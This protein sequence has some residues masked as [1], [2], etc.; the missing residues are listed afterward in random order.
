MNDHQQ[1]R[2]WRRKWRRA[3]P[4]DRRAAAAAL[5]RGLRPAPARWAAVLA[6]VVLSFAA[7]A[8]LLW[9]F[10]HHLRGG[11]SALVAKATDTYLQKVLQRERATRVA[12]ELVRK[13]TMPPPPVDPEAVVAGALTDSLVTDVKKIT[14]GLLDVKLQTAMSAHVAASLKDELAEASKQIAEGKLS[15][16]DIKA[17][18]EKF[19]EKAHAEALAWQKNYREEKQVEI[20]ALSTTEWYEERLSRML[21]RNIAFELF[22]PPNYHAWPP[23]KDMWKNIFCGGGRNLSWG[24][25]NSL[26][27]LAKR[28]ARIKDLEQGLQG[29]GKNRHP[30]WPGPNE[31]QAKLL[32]DEL[33]VLHQG[34]GGD[35]H[36]ERAAPSWRQIVYGGVDHFDTDWGRRDIYFT[37]GVIREYFPHVAGEIRPVAAQIDE[38]WKAAL[39]S[40]NE[41]LELATS[42]QSEPT[43]LKEP[44]QACFSAMKRVRE[45]SEKLIPPDWNRGWPGSPHRTINA[46]LRAQLLTGPNRDEMYQF[47]VERLVTGLSPVVQELV[48]SQ[49]EKGIIVHKEGIEQA[50]K[51]FPKQIVP[52][53]RR[54]VEKILGKPTFEKIVFQSR[55]PYRT[56]AGKIPGE[57]RSEPNDKALK[58]DAALLEKLLERQP[59]LKPYAEARR[60]RLE[61]LWKR[62]LVAVREH[63]LTQ[64]LSGKLLLRDLASYVEGVEYADKVQEKLDARKRAMDGRGQD[65]ARL[66]AEGVPDTSAPLVA[67]MFGASKGHGTSIEP[68]PTTMHPGVFAGVRPQ[69]ALRHTR[70]ALPPLSAKWDL[71]TQAEAKPPFKTSRCEAIPF[72]HRIPRLDGDLS[73]WGTLRPLV[74][75]GQGAE[76]MVYAAWNYQGFFFAYR[77]QQPAQNFYYP[78]ASQMKIEKLPNWGGKFDG[79]YTGR[80]WTEQ[81]KGVA[82]AFRGDYFRVLIDTLDARNRN[83]GEPHTQ[84][85]VI[86]PRGTENNTNSP[87]CERVIASQRDATEKEYRSVQS[88]LSVY[89][90]QPPAEHGPDGSGPFRATRMTADGYE[91]AV[92]L[93]RTLL[94][95]PVFAPGWYI[96]FDCAVQAGFEGRTLR[97]HWAAPSTAIAPEQGGNEPDQWGDLLLLGTDARF[98]VQD[99]DPSY[100]VSQAIVPGHSYLLTVQDP[101]R[102]VKLTEEDTVLVSAESAGGDAEVFVLRET[103][104]NTGIFRG[105]IDTQ[106]GVGRQ[107][108]GVL[109]CV[110]GQEVRFA[111]VDV[112]N[113]RGERNVVT[114]LKLPVVAPIV[115]AANHK[116]AGLP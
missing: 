1:S 71:A 56:Y 42:P 113:A 5:A 88:K 10:R 103:D 77:V 8:G 66:T 3:S 101:D 114:E 102:N 53:L 55:Y 23:S 21:V 40:A 63:I 30:S 95:V 86:F 108:Q 43:Q 36:G 73:R 91:V 78:A 9:T 116:Q 79:S 13:V 12:R 85:F 89:P 17:L 92:F 33:T 6:L 68:V 45:L 64:C 47:W 72:L 70:P 61:R 99:A 28:T 82:W 100:P 27:W 104:K 11:D 25:L 65:L 90:Q 41:Y 37:E 98:H 112:A 35:R 74:L 4:E 54:D 52:L 2:R 111:Y 80:I 97:Q 16:A 107:V 29:N 83:R 26:E 75:K 22:P 34:Y 7:H 87:G 44:Q 15:E 115:S 20:A 81:A 51:E 106:P 48:R 109:E 105:Y 94:N 50:M 67:L 32:V 58:E 14:T 59:D 31:E 24:D 62:T 84:E 19:R 38:Q 69:E 57:K 18:H 49:F 60:K 39:A 93:P 76:S 110:P 46:V 96:G